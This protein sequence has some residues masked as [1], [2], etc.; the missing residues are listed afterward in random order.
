MHLCATPADTRSQSSKVDTTPNL[1]CNMAVEMT[2]QK[3]CQRA[4]EYLPGN[5]RD[6]LCVAADILTSQLTMALDMIFEKFCQCAEK[7]LAG[8]VRLKSLAFF[9][10]FSHM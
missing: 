1:L 8:N 2:F 10:V 9:S 5:G 7:Y 6:K 4:E 3:F